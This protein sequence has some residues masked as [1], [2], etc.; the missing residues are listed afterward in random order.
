M[1]EQIRIA[2]LSILLLTLIL[3]I[4]YPLLIC[5]AGYLFFPHHASGGLIKNQENRVIGAKFI[6]QTFS[7]PYY[8]HSRPSDAGELG[9]DAMASGASNLGPTSKE[10]YQK[11]QER[12]D[13]YRN[14]NNVPSTQK[15]PADAVTASGS[16]LD[17]H[18]S[19]ENANLQ[20]ARIAAARNISEDQI[21]D[22]VQKMTSHRM[23][24]IFGE[25]RVNVL[26]LNI[27]LD[28]QFPMKD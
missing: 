26:M 5:G 18:I 19:Q 4:A 8:F 10:L 20:A 7:E 17:P 11:I 3:G 1:K 24:G 15:L 2:A 21:L 25:P 22:I 12:I 28:Q 27:W 13:R 9:Y 23:L 6:G 14:D 16:G